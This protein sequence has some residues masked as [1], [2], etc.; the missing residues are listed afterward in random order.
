[1]N[2][3]KGPVKTCSDQSGSVETSSR[4][5]HY[6][7][8]NFV[9]H[10]VFQISQPPEITQEWSCIQKLHID[11][12]SQN[13]R[14]LI[15]GSWDNKKKIQKAVF[16]TPCTMAPLVLWYYGT[17]AAK[18]GCSLSGGTHIIFLLRIH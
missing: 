7:L 11:L 6:D 4:Y 2:K 5:S 3:N 18:T 12:N 1:M 16:G 15:L 9:T 10:F 17:G 13:K 14:N 8:V